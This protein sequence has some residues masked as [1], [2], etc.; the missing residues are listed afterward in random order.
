[1]FSAVLWPPTFNVSNQQQLSRLETTGR[2][3]Y[4]CCAVAGGSK[5]DVIEDE[6]RDDGRVREKERDGTKKNG[7]QAISCQNPKLV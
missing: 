6:K 7:W 5:G 1:L 3:Y 2:K 4:D